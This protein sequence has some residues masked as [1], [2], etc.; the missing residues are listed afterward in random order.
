MIQ[1]LVWQ[2]CQDFFAVADRFDEQKDG[3]PRADPEN[4]RTT[5]RHMARPTLAWGW[6]LLVLG[7]VAYW[8]EIDVHG[9]WK[10]GG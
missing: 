9:I 2:A 8:I 4:M 10:V 6:W 1:M 5:V 3:I 7:G